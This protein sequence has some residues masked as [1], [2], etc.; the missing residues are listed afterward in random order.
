VATPEER[1]RILKM[2]QS[3]KISAEQ[4]AQL[5]EALG[6]HTA[7]SEAIPTSPPASPPLPP[8]QGARWLHVTITHSTTGKSSVNLRLPLSLIQAGKKMGARFSPETEE[9]DMNFLQEMIAS[10]KTG[11]VI[12]L[13]K[14]DGRHIEVYL[15]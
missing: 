15:E 2:I 3:G 5:L 13:H 4:G 11:K 1:L 8:R 6:D 12:D 10:G 14:D 9:L 7:P